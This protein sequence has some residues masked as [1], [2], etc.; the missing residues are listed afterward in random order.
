M[1]IEKSPEITVNYSTDQIGETEYT[2]PINFD[3]DTGFFV[4]YKIE[5]PITSGYVI[6]KDTFDN[7]IIKQISF[8]VLN[9]N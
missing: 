1:E 8:E 9:G 4:S 5:N 2:T 7:S 3:Q 6:F